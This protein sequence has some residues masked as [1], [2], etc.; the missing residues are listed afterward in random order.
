MK[1]GI[2]E[3]S[4]YF[5]VWHQNLGRHFEK[6]SLKVFEKGMMIYMTSHV[7][8]RTSITY[9]IILD[10]FKEL[11]VKL[12]ALKNSMSFQHWLAHL[13]PS[14]LVNIARFNT[15]IQIDNHVED[16]MGFISNISWETHDNPTSRN[17]TYVDIKEIVLAVEWNSFHIS[18]KK[19]DY[20]HLKHFLKY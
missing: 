2:R 14:W 15:L 17:T 11:P 7:K 4:S 9:H 16:I 1:I 10:E 12:S 13:S 20:L 8:V 6:L 3:S 5:H 18:E 19:L